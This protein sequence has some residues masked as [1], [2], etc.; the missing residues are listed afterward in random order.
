VQAAKDSVRLTTNQYE[1]GIVSYLNVVVVN[2]TALANEQTAVSI[3][4]Q[5]LAA[6]VQLVSALGGGWSAGEIPSSSDLAAGK[7]WF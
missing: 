1:G 4:G 7:P 5:R 6:S 2:A 3:Q